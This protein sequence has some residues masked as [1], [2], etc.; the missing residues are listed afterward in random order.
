MLL[1]EL[2]IWHTRPITPTRRVAL[3]H[4]VLPTDPAPGLGGVLLAAVV[5]A[6][7]PDVDDELV[8][9]L[10]RLID[11]VTRGERVVQPRLQHRYQVDRHGLAV[12]V[13]QLNGDADN[14]TFDL[15]SMGRPLSQVL[16]AVYALERLDFDA[17]RALAPVLHRA[18]RWRGPIGPSFVADISGVSRGD[19]VGLT[20]PRVWALDLLG[21]PMGT[22]K[23]TKKEVM[24]RFRVKLR[25]AHPDHGG[26]DA[27]AGDAIE[28]LGEARRILLQS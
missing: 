7:L 3:G 12:S 27:V 14:V 17:R 10:G 5:A 20:D 11:Q 23:V 4:L 2:E 25:N 21:F 22:V 18:M 15:H 1:A 13:H 24:A 19:L 28:R 9:D 8:P 16:G 6:Y 26:N